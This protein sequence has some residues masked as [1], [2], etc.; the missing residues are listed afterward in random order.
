MVNK[1]KAVN[2]H[3]KSSLK[4]ISK[5]THEI[6][7]RDETLIFHRGLGNPAQYDTVYIIFLLRPA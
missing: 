3:N 4:P 1:L 5:N 6:G 2:R 7:I